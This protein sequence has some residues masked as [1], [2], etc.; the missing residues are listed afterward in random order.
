MSDDQF[1]QFLSKAAKGYREPPE[2]P[3]DLMWERIQAA[4]RAP[5]TKPTEVIDF[6]SEGRRRRA[7]VWT[8]V[9]AAAVLALGI[10][11]GRLSVSTKRTTVAA[12][13]PADSASV[14]RSETVMRLAA[15]EH[16]S[17]IDALLTDYETGRTDADF[18]VTARELLSRTRLMLDSKRLTDTRLR[19]LL[20]DLELVLV[21][22][23]HLA[24]AP[25]R[26]ER[27]LIDDGI[28]QRQVRLRLRNAI[29]AGPSA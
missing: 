23:S 13:V 5:Q 27:G 9:A 20:L 11:I 26:E 14:R 2:T 15:A 16:F 4:R 10:G 3:R 1:E 12:A 25:S 29:P 6:A 22:V 8:G 28:N 21:Q 17:R 18:Q 24:P 7:V 19:A